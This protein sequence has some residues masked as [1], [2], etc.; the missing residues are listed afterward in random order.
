M[1]KI[2]NLFSFF[3]LITISCM[4]TGCDFLDKIITGKIMIGNN[5]NNMIVKYGLNKNIEIIIP[6]IITTPFKISAEF[7]E[8]ISVILLTSL[9]NLDI[10]SPEEFWSKYLTGNF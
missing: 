5:P 3:L 1:K 8:N 7:C 4:L 2:I 6:K 9:V 10:K